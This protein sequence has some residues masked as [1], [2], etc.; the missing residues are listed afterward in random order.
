MVF[1]WSRRNKLAIATAFTDVPGCVV[2]GGDYFFLLTR[3]CVGNDIDMAV[4]GAGVT[5]VFFR[6]DVQTGTT[7]A[8]G[9]GAGLYLMY[10]AATAG[11]KYRQQFASG[12][13]QTFFNV[14]LALELHLAAITQNM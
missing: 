13:T 7:D 5:Q 8:D 4:A 14:V 3:V 10:G 6:L 2:M 1:H 11:T 9:R 12:Q